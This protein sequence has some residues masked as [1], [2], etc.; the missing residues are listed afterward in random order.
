MSF[1]KNVLIENSLNLF[2][3]NLLILR[4]GLG[5][6]ITNLWFYTRLIMYFMILL[7]FIKELLLKSFEDFLT[8]LFHQYFIL[9][10]KCHKFVWSRV[11]IQLIF[12]LNIWVEYSF[13]SWRNSHPDDIPT[14]LIRTLFK[15]QRFLRE[16]IEVGF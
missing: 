11:F 4:L 16:I 14:S 1:P 13:V 10:P 8:H 7:L 12:S 3:I 15:V 5:P 6:R 9:R 2:R